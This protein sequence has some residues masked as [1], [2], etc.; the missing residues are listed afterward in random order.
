MQA[1]EM[2][3]AALGDDTLR[4]EHEARA[5]SAQR[6]A[7]LALDRGREDTAGLQHAIVVAGQVVSAETALLNRTLAAILAA[8]GLL[9]AAFLAGCRWA[10]VD[11]LRTRPDALDADD[12]VDLGEEVEAELQELDDALLYEPSEATPG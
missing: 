12:V 3:T 7:D 6:E 9:G 5:R 10:S 8:L 2:R 1:V 4:G 11:D